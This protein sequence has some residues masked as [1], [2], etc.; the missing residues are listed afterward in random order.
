MRG[1]WREGK[2]R[3]WEVSEMGESCH[4][5][6]LGCTWG[7]FS[8]LF[9]RRMGFDFWYASFGLEGSGVSDDAR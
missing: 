5:G 6:I 1:M 4:S 3:G 2:F 8:G 9:T 7:L